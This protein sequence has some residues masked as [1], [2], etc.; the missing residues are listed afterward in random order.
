MTHSYA[1]VE[2]GLK[3]CQKHEAA[4][5]NDHIKYVCHSEKN[6]FELSNLFSKHDCMHVMLHVLFVGSR[7]LWLLKKTSV[8]IIPKRFSKLR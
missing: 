1:N 8:F 2:K 3:L 4:D 6:M 7:H 5:S